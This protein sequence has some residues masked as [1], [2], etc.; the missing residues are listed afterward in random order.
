VEIEMNFHYTMPE[1]LKAKFSNTPDITFDVETEYRIALSKNLRP[2][3]VIEKS[4]EHH[5]SMCVDN[6]E[7][8]VEAKQLANE[9]AEDIES[10]VR[11]F[12]NCLSSSTKNYRE[13]LIEDYKTRLTVIIGRKFREKIFSMD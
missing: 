10:R 4:I 2:K 5:A 8:L 13:W 3:V 12:T 6:S 7:T 9:L 1:E 11:H